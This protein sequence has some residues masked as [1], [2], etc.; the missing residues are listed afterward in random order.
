MKRMLAPVAVAWLLGLHVALAA[1]AD[2]ADAW[3][4]LFDGKSLAGWKAAENPDS[5]TARDGAIVFEGPRA[6]LY[7]SGDVGG[8][9]FKNF[10]LKVDVMTA[11]GA[12]SGVYFHTRY[13]PSGWPGS[14]FEVQINNTQPPHGNYYEFK[15]TGSL[16]GIRNQFKSIAPDNRWFTMHIAVTGRRVRT[17][18][19]GHLLV[20]YVEPAADGQRRRRS[21]NRGTFALQGHD[22]TSKVSF[23]NIRV[24]RLPDEST[25]DTVEEPVVDQRYR[26]ILALQRGNF[27]LVDFHVHLKGGLTLEEAL[28]ASR[29]TGVNFGIAANCGV[30]F[31]I[32]DDEGIAKYLE[33]MKGQPCFVGMQAEG[34]EWV[35]NFSK[36]AIAKFD[37]VFTDA[38]TFTD[39]RGRRVRLWMKDEVV[40][41]DK[42]AFMEMLV[43]RI[44]TILNNEPIDLYVNPTYLP[45]TIADEYDELWTPERMQRVIDAAAKNHVAVEINARL[46]LPNAAFIKGAKQAGVK[47]S[48]GTNN[49]GKELGRLDY[50]LDMIRECGLKPSDMFMPKGR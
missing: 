35:D 30:G 16:Y 21:L 3:T 46:R 8:A 14:G 31:P 28:A 47:F 33:T 37:Y 7:Y 40:V 44:V 15:K 43:E 49:T 5:F 20:D 41:G 13:R 29:A 18:V 12:N 26:E 17:W 36:E 50:A 48:L 32:T 24:K 34:R 9:N 45:A 23:K 42:Q 25:D 39:H 22:P 1:A 2:D 6:H 38:M 27:P 4:P 19:D 11:P 10:E